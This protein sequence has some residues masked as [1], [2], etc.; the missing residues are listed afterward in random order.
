MQ[1]LGQRL[2]LP[3]EPFGKRR[4]AAD[5]RRQHLQCNDAVELFLAGFIDRAHAALADQ[6]DDLQLRER[7]GQAFE[8]GRFGPLAAGLAGIGGDGRR[9]HEAFGADPLRRIRRDGRA[10]TGTNS[11]L[12]RTIHTWL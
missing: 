6:L 1:Q 2:R 11:M 4:A 5:A 7:S 10:A 9:R 3:G 12:C 8:R